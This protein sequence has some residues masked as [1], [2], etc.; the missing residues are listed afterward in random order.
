MDGAAGR[1]RQR[2]SLDLAEIWPHVWAVA[3]GQ[4]REDVQ[5]V[6]GNYTAAGRLAVWG[7]L[8]LVLALATSWWPAALFALALLVT[9][10]RR[11]RDAID[12]L[13]VLV[14]STVDLYVRAVAERLGVVCS[15]P[16]STTTA[17]RINTI[18]RPTGP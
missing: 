18:L 15:D 2:Y 5:T 11:A 12:T 3:D 8:Y 9:A 6:R 13:A 16:F 14:E 7:G 1:V 17:S 4:V 10:R